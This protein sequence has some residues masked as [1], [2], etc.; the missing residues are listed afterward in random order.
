MD[1]SDILKEVQNI[2]REG[3]L[4]KQSRFFK[5]WR[6]Y[7]CTYQTLGGPHQQLPLHLQGAQGLREPHRNHPPQGHRL[8]QSSRVGD[9][10]AALLRTPPSH[11][12]SIKQRNHLLLF[13][14]LHPGAVE[15]DWRYWYWLHNLGKA[16]IKRSNMH[17]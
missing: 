15:L 9:R 8:H 5:S 13:I 17:M 4:Q 1:K 16:M 2:H 10:Q 3:F 7:A 12:E 14:G 6:Q 11:S